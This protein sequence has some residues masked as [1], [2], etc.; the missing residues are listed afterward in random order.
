LPALS[1]FTVQTESLL[2]V[3]IIDSTGL[4]EQSE[5]NFAR[6]ILTLG[7]LMQR[8]LREEAV[9]FLQCTGDGFFACFQSAEMALNVAARLGPGVARHVGAGIRVAVAL[10]W[11]PTRNTGNGG[12]AGRDVYAVFALEKVRH[13]TAELEA[14][15]KVPGD[16][17]FI[18]MTETFWNQLGP[19]LRQGAHVVGAF[20]L[21]GLSEEMP[22][23]YWRPPR[24]ADATATRPTP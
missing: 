4:L 6:A 22:V 11:G 2:V 7:Q 15:S 14:A 18:L 24:Q 13:L 8:G 20:W 19:E 10:H 12:K 3:D 9:P 16:E 1:T 5:V 17:S 23:F 21:R